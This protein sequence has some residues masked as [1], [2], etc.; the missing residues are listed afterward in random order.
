MT[1]PTRLY[2][3]TTYWPLLLFSKYMRGKAVAVH[4]KS[5]AYKGK[6][7]PEWVESTCTIPKLDVSAATDGEWMNL[8]VVNS[9]EDKSFATELAGVAPPSGEVQVYLVGGEA[10]ALTDINCEGKELIKINESLWKP[11]E[12]NKLVF[13][14]HSFTLLRW[15]L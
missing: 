14:R 13:E 11:E 3:Q 8:A 7:S 4:V 10:S 5:A 2:K 1:S 6:T 12:G 15:K 9:D